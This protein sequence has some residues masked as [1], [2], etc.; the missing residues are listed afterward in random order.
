MEAVADISYL[1]E[2]NPTTMLKLSKKISAYLTSQGEV[3]SR[4]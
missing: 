4:R 2:L 3:N 1:A